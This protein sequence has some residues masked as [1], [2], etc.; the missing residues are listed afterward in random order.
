ME[1]IEIA[2]K[3]K[4]AQW[5]K[6][7]IVAL[8]TAVVTHG[9]PSPQNYKLALELEELIEKA[10]AVPATVGVLDGVIKVGLSEKEI[11]RLAEGGDVSKVGPR[12]FS[13]VL[14][15]GGCG[16][17]TVGGTLQ[18]I[19]HTEIMVFATGGIGGVHRGNPFD[20]SADLTTLGSNRAIVVCS[21]AKSILD[22]P[23]TLEV[24]ETQMVPVVGY[25]CDHFPAFYA[26]S[27]GLPIHIR[28]DEISQVV[29]IANAHWMMDMVSS[30]LL[31]V[32]P[33]QEDALRDE[34]M[35]EAVEKALEAVQEQKIS[36]GAV[37]PFLLDR[38]S[39]LTEGKS[40]QANL[41]LLRNNAL[42]AAEVAKEYHKDKR[43][44]IGFGGSGD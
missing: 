1:Y 16:G 35:K 22:L 32:P 24:L 43:W 5:R 10:G 26:R 34:E 41:S 25:Q 13:A 31:V 37:T 39:E 15:R 40:L 30:L 42:L 21:G 14:A 27:S 44:E 23:A 4:E 9:L 17:T 29:E 3:V 7:P 11:Q 36:G 33:P 18:A 6:K 20:V 8:E 38:V 2:E 28:V 12:D 19:K